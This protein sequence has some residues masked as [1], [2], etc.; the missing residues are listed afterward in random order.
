MSLQVMATNFDPPGMECPDGKSAPAYSADSGVSCDSVGKHECTAKYRNVVGR[1]GN[2]KLR[3][4]LVPP[5][6]TQKNGPEGN[7]IGAIASRKRRA[8][9]DDTGRDLDGETPPSFS[10]MER[11]AP[12]SRTS[13]NKRGA[14]P[15]VPC[16]TDPGEI[17]ELD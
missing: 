3:H 1:D 5:S 7:S 11:V 13:P 12:E 14:D 9:V 17:E 2:G 15:D 10:L 6:E 8:P 16:D 4:F